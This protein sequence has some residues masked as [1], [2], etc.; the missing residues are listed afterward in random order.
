[1]SRFVGPSRLLEKLQ[2][3]FHEIFKTEIA[4]NMHSVRF[5]V[6]LE[7]DVGSLC[8]FGSFIHIILCL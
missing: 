6:D 2:M 8:I 7:P 5:L 4:R 3:N 1:M